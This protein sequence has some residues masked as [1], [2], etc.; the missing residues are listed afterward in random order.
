MEAKWPSE[1]LYVRYILLTTIVITAFLVILERGKILDIRYFK[2]ARLCHSGAS[3]EVPR[4]LFVQTFQLFLLCPHCNGV[5][6][7]NRKG[8]QASPPPVCS[9][10]IT[11]CTC[12]V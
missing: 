11:M 7:W 3:L 12:V 6:D 4:T 2:K 1:I 10:S 5:T 9:T 8:V